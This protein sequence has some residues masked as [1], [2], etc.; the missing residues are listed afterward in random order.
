MVFL[1]F[2][3]RS[4]A[5]AATV[6]IV[7][8]KPLGAARAGAQSAKLFQPSAP[9]AAPADAQ[10]AS[11]ADSSGTAKDSAISANF[12]AVP[13]MSAASH[14]AQGSATKDRLSKPYTESPGA[15]VSGN[16]D[17][18]STAQLQSM[19]TSAQQQKNAGP[20]TRAIAPAMPAVA[21]QDAG[22]AIQFAAT[23]PNTDSTQDLVTTYSSF[24][25]DQVYP[26]AA[27]GATPAVAYTASGNLTDSFDPGAATTTHEL[28]AE[29][30]GDTIQV[31]SSFDDMTELQL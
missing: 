14:A 26:Y 10:A 13:A 29:S 24:N 7:P 5:A 28:H 21:K 20:K 23:Q 31:S 3:C 19:L 15:P 8:P 27:F 9:A 2:L 1:C 17:Q 18:H 4:N 16:A 11:T 12:V 22:A 6:P 30:H 25:H